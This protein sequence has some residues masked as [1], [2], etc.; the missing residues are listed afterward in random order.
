M[1]ADSSPRA[2]IGARS[3]PF[4]VPT[5]DGA[6]WHR[7]LA[8]GRFPIDARYAT[9]YCRTPRHAR[10]ALF[11]T[12]GAAAPSARPRADAPEPRRRLQRLVS[13][14]VTA[15]VLTL[16]VA[17]ALAVDRRALRPVTRGDTSLQPTSGP[18]LPIRR[19]EAGGEALPP[20]TPLATPAPTARSAAVPPSLV[21]APSPTPLP[22][23]SASVAA[24]STDT[25]PPAS[26]AT[27]S[28]IGRRATEGPPPPPPTPEMRSWGGLDSDFFVSPAGSDAAD[29]RSPITAWRTFAP[30]GAGRVPGG[31]TVAA[32]AGGVWEET[33]RPGAANLHFRPYGTGTRPVIVAPDGEY[34]FD[35]NQQPGLRLTGWEF[36]AVTRRGGVLGIVLID[37]PGYVVQ[38]IVVHG[39]DGWMFTTRGARGLVEGSEFYDNDGEGPTHAVNIGGHEGDAYPAAADITIFRANHIHDTGYRGLSNWGTNILFESNRIERWSKAGLLGSATQAPAGIYL[40]SNNPGPLVVRGNSLVGVGIENI[41]IWVDDGPADRTIVEGNVV[42]DAQQ[43][44]WAEKTDNVIFRGNT[45]TRMR[46]VGVRWGSGDRFQDP[47]ENGQIVD[48]VF[49]GTPPAEGWIKLYPGATA[50]VDRNEFRP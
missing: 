15:T 11:L 45:C 50:L 43:C 46:R 7:C 4:F 30:L 26:T 35:G 9:S 17:L 20:P 1:T 28:M 44:F 39:V 3:C 16:V 41:G 19:G 22:S 32:E 27:V 33:V 40:Q 21:A 8:D 37:R 14:F 42:I 24:V 6:D 23:A 36:T 25:L 13:T 10:C 2:H 12:A 34:A 48:N 47:S 38:D 5:A 29:G 31:A 18:T 49:V